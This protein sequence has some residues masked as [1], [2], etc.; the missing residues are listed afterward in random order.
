M[1]QKKLTYKEAMQRFMKAKVHKREVINKLEKI[2]KA[3]YEKETGLKA[4]YFFAM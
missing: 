4:D 3:E 1:D 2:M